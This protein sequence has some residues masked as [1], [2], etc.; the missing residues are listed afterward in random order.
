MTAAGASGPALVGGRRRPVERVRRRPR[1]RVNR[2]L[3]PELRQRLGLAGP[4][5]E[6]GAPEQTLGLLLA[7]RAPVFRDG[8]PRRHASKL[9]TG[10][11]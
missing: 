2:V 7:E 1:Q 4:G 11:G 9:T 8:R 5:A 10:R 6:A 3:E